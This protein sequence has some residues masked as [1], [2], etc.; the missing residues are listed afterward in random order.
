[1]Y[2]NLLKSL[3]RLHPRAWDFIQLTRM[4]KPIG[5]YLLLWPTLSALW[6][7]AKGVPSLGNLLIFTLGVILTRAGGCAIND[8]ADRKV[9][10]HVKRT[11]QRPIAA[12]RISG[13]EALA[14]F[15]LL[16]VHE[17]LHLLPAGGA[18]RGVFLGHP[19]GLHR[20]D[21]QP[22]GHGLVALYRQ[23]AVDGGVRHLLRHD[24][25]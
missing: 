22:A 6:I 12:G 17:A 25:P 2:L 14:V 24:R 11:E 23:C 1:M 4:D 7:A 3:N 19:D 10:G 5:I 16:P 15:G 18:G 20:R 8:F 9:D 13:K 21:R